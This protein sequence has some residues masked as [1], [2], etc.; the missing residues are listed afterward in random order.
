MDLNVSSP[1]KVFLKNDLFSDVV[2]HV[3]SPALDELGPDRFKMDSLGEDL[4]DDCTRKKRKCPESLKEKSIETQTDICSLSGGPLPLCTVSPPP[5]TSIP[6]STSSATTSTASSTPNLPLTEP[7]TSLIIPL[8]SAESLTNLTTLK[9]MGQLPPTPIFSTV[10]GACFTL[11]HP[12]AAPPTPPTVPTTPPSNDHG[13]SPPSTSDHLSPSVNVPP[14]LPPCP[15]LQSTAALAPCSSSLSTRS[16]SPLPSPFASGSTA[17]PNAATCA[18]TSTSSSSTSTSTSTSSSLPSSHPSTSTTSKATSPKPIISLNGHRCVLAAHSKF[19][20]VMFSNGMKESFE[21][22]VKVYVEDVQSFEKMFEYFY[23]G[24][25]DFKNSNLLS[26]LELCIQFDVPRLS[27]D[28]CSYLSANITFGNA[29]EVFEF[30]RTRLDKGNPLSVKS[31]EFVLGNFFSIF[32]GYPPSIRYLSHTSLKEL[33]I[34]DKLNVSMEFYAF[35]ALRYWA[36]HTNAKEFEIRELLPAIRFAQI[37]V[38]RLRNLVRPSKLGVLCPDLFRHYMDALEYHASSVDM[39]PMLGVCDLWRRKRDFYKVSE[40]IPINWKFKW[41]G[42]TSWV[43]NWTHLQGYKLFATLGKHED[44]TFG[45]YFVP[46]ANEQKQFCLKAELK[47]YLLNEENIPLCPE[48]KLEPTIFKSDSKTP[49]NSIAK[50]WATKINPALLVN[51]MIVMKIK[52][53]ICES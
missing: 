12:S 32:R 45:M 24:T 42:L 44:G 15:S 36:E 6:S 48:L 29:F 47:V 20:Y 46:S 3:F 35:M 18:S 21:K 4:E 49:L 26:L 40:F 14:P 52:A 9:E 43:Y 39:Q 10:S 50:G 53:R 51:D 33:L 5:C 22:E 1:L 19:F 41:S 27:C 2:L 8:C 30:A 23:T 16:S 7:E 17:S 11:S 37:D 28:V 25:I 38:D 31:M 34:N 13:T